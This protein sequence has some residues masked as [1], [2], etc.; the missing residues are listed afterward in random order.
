MIQLET[1]T[2]QYMDGNE[3]KKENSVMMQ[4]THHLLYPD[5]VFF[6]YEVSFNTGIKNDGNNVGPKFVG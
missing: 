1:P 5:M 4:V 3:V 6:L 2:L